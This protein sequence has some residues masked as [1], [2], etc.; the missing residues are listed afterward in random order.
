VVG[1]ALLLLLVVTQAVAIA[2]LFDFSPPPWHLWLMV[3]G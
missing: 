1:S 3:L 2:P